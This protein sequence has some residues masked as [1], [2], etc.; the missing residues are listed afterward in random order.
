MFAVN[1]AAVNFEKAKE[2]YARAREGEKSLLERLSQVSFR[3]LT[4][5]STQFSSIEIGMN[6]E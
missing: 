2:E 3:T 4:T 6:Y 5:V 1:N